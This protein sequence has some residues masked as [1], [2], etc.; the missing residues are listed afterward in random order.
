MRSPVLSWLTS[1]P[2]S[3]SAFADFQMPLARGKEERRHAALRAHE[4]VEPVLTGHTRDVRTTRRRRCPATA[5]T[6]GLRLLS[7]ARS[8][9]TLGTTSGARSR[10]RP[11]ARRRGRRWRAAPGPPG[12]RPGTSRGCRCGCAAAGSARTTARTTRLRA[13][14]LLLL[15]LAEELF[16]RAR[17][18]GE[19][20]DLRRDV[21]VRPTLEQHLH[22][23][24]AVVVGREHERRLAAR[25][26]FGVR[27]GT[28]IEQH[29]DRVGLAGR[30]GEHQRGRPVGR[31]DLRIR[32]GFDERVEQRRAAVLAR[33]NERRVAAQPGR[34]LHVGAGVEQHLGELGV[35]LTRRPMQRR[36]AV[37]F[38]GVDVHALFQERAHRLAIAGLGGFRN[39]R[40]RRRRQHH[41]Q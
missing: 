15:L 41:R 33:Q 35:A 3:R 10:L 14:A 13:A 28:G 37:A 1:A 20:H 12:P 19:I 36:H 38:S 8:T 32:A 27:I 7:A 4:L 30:G 26:L 5:T 16:F 22:R 2:A 6:A 9:L 23:V 17:Q 25:V 24:D 40:R 29:L 11:A 21:E 31:R 34:G 39:R 18:A